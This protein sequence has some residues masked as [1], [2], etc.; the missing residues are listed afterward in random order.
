M[1]QLP[2]KKP[3]LKKRTERSK[4][5]A[6]LFTTTNLELQNRFEAWRESIAVIMDVRP[7]T[8]APEPL[9]DARVESY[10]LEDIVF[11]RCSAGAQKF[12]RSSVRVARDSIDHYM[13]QLFLAGSMDMTYRGKPSTLKPGGLIAFDFIE[14]MDSFNSD[15]DLLSVIIPRRRLAPMLTNPELM[16]G[17]QVDPQSGAGKLLINFVTTLYTVIPTL[18][19]AEAGLA[20]R[21]LVDLT[22]LAFNGATLQGGDIPGLAQQ[23]VLLQI[24]T[25]IKS[26]LHESDLTPDIVADAVGVSRAQ[27]YRLFAPIGGISE[28]IREQRLRR[29][30]ADLLS[31]KH[32]SRQISD[33]AYSWGFRDPAYFT[34]AFKQRFGR[35]PSDA[36]QA[37]T[38]SQPDRSAPNDLIGDRLYEQWLSGIS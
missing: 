34:K 23:P 35:S 15:F 26:Q 1:P 9:F 22:A 29:C 10:L 19:D 20:A 7:Q 6:S 4:I 3:D 18:G 8:A 11:S 32:A 21:S 12:D 36:R 38:S 24:Q 2:L 25:Y 33:I 16:Q 27:L 28:Y 5:P 13:I 17:A 37:M 31:L 30:L 14:V